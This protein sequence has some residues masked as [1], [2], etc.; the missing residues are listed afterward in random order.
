MFEPFFTTKEVGKGTGLGLSQVYGFARQS[1]GTLKVDSAPGQGTTVTIY[2]PRAPDAPAPKAHDLVHDN[3]D[4]PKDAT[5]LVVEDNA[6]VADVCRTYLEQ[7][8]YRVRHAENADAALHAMASDGGIDLVLTDIV[9][10]GAMNG[11]DLARRLRRDHP[12]LPI[13]LT[14]GY[15]T[16]AALAREE[17]PLIRKPYSLAEL[18]KRMDEALGRRG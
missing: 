9:M 2:L 18:R 5:V 17:F 3:V 14:T 15:S 4:A 10:A 13:I 6:Q 11:V 7:L 8:G 16:D 12:G 1:G